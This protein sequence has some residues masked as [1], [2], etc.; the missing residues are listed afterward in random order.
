[1][2]VVMRCLRESIINMDIFRKLKDS[3]TEM[4]SIVEQH[5]EKE[6]GVSLE[7]LFEDFYR[8]FSER[9][10]IEAI[11]I[12][13]EERYIIYKDY[14]SGE[15][16][17]TSYT[18]GDTITYGEPERVDVEY[19]PRFKIF[20]DKDNTPKFMSISSTA[21]LNRVN[22]IDSTAL[23][24]DF[25]V[26]YPKQPEKAYLTIRHLGEVSDEF[27]FGT[28]EGVFR[29]D[30]VLVTYGTIDE[31]KELGRL[32]IQRLSE[33][34]DWGVSIGFRA[35][36]QPQIIEE[37]G[38]KIPV[39]ERGILL[40]VSI[41]REYEAASYYTDIGLTER[42]KERM[43]TKD[44]ISSILKDFGASEEA[45][46]GLLSDVEIR[47]REIEE[48]NLITREVNEEEQQEQVEEEQVEE[49]VEEREI[50]IDDSVIEQ[51]V[52]QAESVVVALVEQQ[53]T[54][55]MDAIKAE[56]EKMRS[57][58]E[59]RVESV[60]D[61]PKERVV[62]KP[63]NDN[64]SDAEKPVTMSELVKSRFSN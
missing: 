7:F 51:I 30:K 48:Q 18:L 53:L 11:N 47:N 6:R 22:E 19:V 39:Y 59:E 61:K 62:Y 46:D 56:N 1:M 52:R 60:I 36:K 17:R 44:Q 5:E 31:S 21:I 32:A 10:Y 9:G 57:A 41:L 40:E 27:R 49:V 38:L 15:T 12:D 25:E 13:I 58:I 23:Y 54:E 3:I 29:N 43:K 37:N 34:S 4:L 16:Y 50:T 14:F 24:D 55:F 2:K 33:E 42:G 8:N 35:T 26:N 20:R 45:I 63:T 28:V 64:V